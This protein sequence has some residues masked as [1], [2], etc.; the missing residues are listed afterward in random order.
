MTARD[1][2]IAIGFRR[3][4]PEINLA[5]DAA[6]AAGTRSLYITDSTAEVHDGTSWT[7]H[8]AVRGDDPYDRYTGAISLLHYLGVTL[9]SVSGDKGRKRLKDIETLHERL[10]EFG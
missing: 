4:V 2:F 5:L 6:N 1:L 8:C 7:I 10:Q 9:M 3:R